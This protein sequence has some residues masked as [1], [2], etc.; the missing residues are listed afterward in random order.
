MPCL[1]YVQQVL[2]F[3]FAVLNFL[4]TTCYPSYYPSTTLRYYILAV[5]TCLPAFY[6]LAVFLLTLPAYVLAVFLLTCLP[7]HYVLAVFL[8]T[9]LPAYYVLAVFLLTLQSW[10]SCLL[11]TSCQRSVFKSGPLRWGA[12]RQQGQRRGRATGVHAC[13]LSI[14][15]VLVCPCVLLCVSRRCESNQTQICEPDLNS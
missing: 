6:V 8:L 5:L 3:S 12:V 13:Y 14:V 1:V 15:C 11:R 10:S 7:A 2:S 9:C 4:L